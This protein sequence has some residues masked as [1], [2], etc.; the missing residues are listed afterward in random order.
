MDF[1][2]LLTLLLLCCV[3]PSLFTVGVALWALLN[4]RKWLVPTE[5]ELQARFTRL[6]ASGKRDE[7]F[8]DHIVRAQALRAGI[9]G[10]VTS[11]GGVFFLPVGLVIDLY[12]S[13]RLQESTL[14][15]IAWANGVR[16]EEELLS[17]TEF[18]NRKPGYLDPALVASTSTALTQR[19][20]RRVL[21]EIA[22]KAF[23][24]LIPGL[25]MLVG[26][27]INYYSLRGVAAVARRY[28]Q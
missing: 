21:R 11:V 17:Y 27:A 26:Y 18:L 19:L 28:Y 23:A 14:R 1:N 24:K 13:T 9:V 20:V 10:A 25:G 6:Q 12:A 5:A 8:V 2:D 22:E 15:L 7:D 16:S 3:L 4:A